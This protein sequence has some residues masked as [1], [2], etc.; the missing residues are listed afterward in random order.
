MRQEV[1]PLAGTQALCHVP[2][3]SPPAPLRFFSWLLR[4]LLEATTKQFLK[5]P[6][7]TRKS[8][9]LCSDFKGE[10]SKNLQMIFSW[11]GH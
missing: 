10:N 9:S 11:A 4:R 6:S 7:K 1:T 5:P 2:G 8:D 3:Q